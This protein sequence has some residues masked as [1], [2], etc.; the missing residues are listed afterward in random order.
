MDSMGQARFSLLE[1]QDLNVSWRT[2]FLQG[3]VL[4]DPFHQQLLLVNKTT[5]KQFSNANY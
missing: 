4:H 5:T 1:K 3:H 2:M